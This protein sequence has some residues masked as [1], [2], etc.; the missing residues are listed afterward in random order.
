[1]DCGNLNSLSKENVED[2]S[3]L[4]G[5]EESRPEL[6]TY[7]KEED[8][9]ATELFKIK[10]KEDKLSKLINEKESS[11]NNAGEE[12]ILKL[13]NEFWSFNGSRVGGDFCVIY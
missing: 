11:T 1:M 7:D 5:E 13:S 4:W 2:S 9:T 10:V 8:S 6:K 12:L 3:L